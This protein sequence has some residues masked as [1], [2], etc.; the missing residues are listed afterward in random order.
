M[1]PQT[2]GDFLQ[3]CDEM[4]V[5]R[6]GLTPAAR[7]EVRSPQFADPQQAARCLLWLVGPYRDA[8]MNGGPAAHP[9]A[10]VEDGLLNAPC[11]GDSFDDV[12]RIDRHI[13]NGG[14]TRDPTRCLRIC[15]GWDDVRQT[16]IVAHMPSHR[17]TG[18]T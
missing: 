18:A 14:T 1:L 11:G 15:H 2:W 10:R 16:V 13:K 12:V 17:V 9:N 8:R 4:L 6:V 5:T 7:R 3:W